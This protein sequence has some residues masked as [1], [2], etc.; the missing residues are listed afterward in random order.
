MTALGALAGVIAKTAAAR[1][2]SDV[3]STPA[4]LH[5]PAARFKTTLLMGFLAQ[6]YPNVVIVM[7]FLLFCLLKCLK[8]RLA[9][10]VRAVICQRSHFQRY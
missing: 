9:R 5:G 2:V 3:I 1:R 4:Q 6:L 7:N 10:R 8:A